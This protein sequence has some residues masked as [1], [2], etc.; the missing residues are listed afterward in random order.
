MLILD[1]DKIKQHE[2]KYY[3]GVSGGVDSMVLLDLFVKNIPASQIVVVY[4]NHHLQPLNN[5]WEVF[6]INTCDN[7]G[8]SCYVQDVFIERG[9]GVEAKARK[10]RYMAFSNLTP[11]IH[12]GH[13]LSDQVETSLFRLVKGYKPQ[14]L[15]G[16]NEISQLTFDSMDIKVLR[17]L[18]PFSKREI[19][20]YAYENNL[21]W[22]EDPSNMDECYS[23]NLLRNSIIPKLCQMNPSFEKSYSRSMNSI[24]RICDYANEHLDLVLSERTTYS[25]GKIKLDVSDISDENK[26]IDL[27]NRVLSR[28]F[29]VTLTNGQERELKKGAVNA[30]M[31]VHKIILEKKDNIFYFFKK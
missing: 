4:V 19:Y 27:V 7:L 30:N 29:N 12:T 31:T 24:D 2:G 10:E 6:V 21:E 26:I 17:P 14:S 20:D 9:R 28:E 8:V 11:V 13:H 22:V 15:C 23:R 18:L 1:K 16:M 3:L 25:E 5:D